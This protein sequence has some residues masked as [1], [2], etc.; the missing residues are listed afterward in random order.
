MDTKAKK[1]F[2]SYSW[3]NPEHQKW[4]LKLATDL[5]SKYGIDVILDQFELSAGKDLTYFM[6]RS[7]EVS[8]KVLIIL[9]PNYKLKAENREKGVGY[10]TSIISQ[11]IFESLITT[12][13]FI[14]ILRSGTRKSASPKHLSSKVDHDM[15]DDDHYIQ[16]VFEL[17]RVINE[18]PLI[19]KPKLGNVPDYKSDLIDPIIEIGTSMIDEATINTELDI[20]IGSPEGLLL[21]RNETKNLNATLK[22]KIELYREAIPLPFSFESNDRDISIIHCLGYSVS[23]YWRSSYSNSATG[24]F[25]EVK[26]W[27]GFVRANSNHFYFDH[28]KPKEVKRFKF[29]FDLNYEKKVAWKESND[30]TTT[31]RIIQEAFLFIIDRIKIDK[32]KNFRK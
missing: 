3:D 26:H 10:E 24:S 6:E 4:V 29:E 8:D 14:P 11:E 9:T 22:S 15:R 25:I 18:L 28:E 23:F 20:L 16:Q 12:V 31:E 27:I 17:S 30:R 13:K 1:V 21:F 19:E 32:S 5:R 7:I 2:I